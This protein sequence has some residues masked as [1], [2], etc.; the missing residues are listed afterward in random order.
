MSRSVRFGKFRAW[1]VHRQ[2]FKFSAKNL[3]GCSLLGLVARVQAAR[4]NDWRSG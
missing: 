3:I 4:L 1:H 2:P